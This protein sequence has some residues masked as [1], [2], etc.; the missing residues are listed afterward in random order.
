MIRIAS[1]IA[2]TLLV[3]YAGLCL[4]LYIFQRSLMYFPQPRADVPGTEVIKLNSGDADLNITTS[5]RVNSDAVLYFGG[6]AEDVSLSVADLVA[7]FPHK[8]I[9]ALHYRSYGGSSGK[10][11]EKS[12]VKDG[13]FLFDEIKNK[14]ANITVIGR[15]LGSGVAIQVASQRKL[16]R[17]VLVTPYDSVQNIAANQFPIFPVRMLLQDKFES[18]EFAKKLSVPTL[19]IAAEND[20]VIPLKNTK[21]LLSSFP[22][23]IVQFAVL[24]RT[25]HNSISG[26]PEYIKLLSGI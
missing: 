9:Y 20:E 26:S 12:L 25:G 1:T 2:V 13:L 6:N 22:R 21:V 11:S 7:A 10:P 4:V 15:S 16:A 18:L 5:Q 17:L 23:E 14:H 8:A 3:V 24:P 19:I